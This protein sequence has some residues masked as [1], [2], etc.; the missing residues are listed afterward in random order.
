MS[1]APIAVSIGDPAGIGPE[2]LA[3]AWVRRAQN[4]L[5]PFF[6]IGD[7]RSI[8]TVWKGPLRKV[9]GPAEAVACFGEALPI[10]EVEDAGAIVPGQP[11]M[12]GARCAIASLEIAV[13]LAREGAASAIVTGPVSKAEL[14]AI[15]FTHAG[16]TEFVAERCGVAP[17]NVAMMLA[18][19]TLRTVCITTHV[20][21]ARVSEL[22]SVELVVS[23]AR[24]TAR[25]LQRDFGIADPRIAIAGFN[26]HAGEGG[27]LGREEI[28]ILLP[29]IEQ[30][31][32]EGIDIVGPLAADTMF[33]PRARARYDAALCTYHDQAL[34]PLKT[35]HFDEGVNMTLGLPIVRVAPDHGTAF[36]IAGKGLSEPGATIAAIRMAGEAAERR[37]AAS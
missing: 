36:E 9:D 16:Q 14:Y 18:G 13:G 2:V 30:L 17:G 6:A 26:P 19:P 1:V 22:L 8:S 7:L 24:V 15:G 3:K 27:S 10:M 28:E 37:A 20:P 11:N 21:L 5:T 32:D 23:R 4:R 33:H 25:G 29:A 31:R 35:L 12:P 34:I